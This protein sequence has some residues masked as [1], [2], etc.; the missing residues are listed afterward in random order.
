MADYQLTTPDPDGS[1]LRTADQAWI[2]ADP[3]NRDYAE[4]QEWLAK[5]NVPDPYVP[6]PEPEPTP[7]PEDQVLY[8][9]ENRIRELEG[10]PPLTLDEF[11]AKK[12][13]KMNAGTNKD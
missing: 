10:V 4:Y 11:K 7:S 3:A 9:H 1:V 2:P 6:P 13:E 8:N 5:G 12:L